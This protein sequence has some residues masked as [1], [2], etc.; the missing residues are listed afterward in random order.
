MASTTRTPLEEI[1][2]RQA[3]QQ[4][5][6]SV[7]QKDL[8]GQLQAVTPGSLQ[9]RAEMRGQTTPGTTP[10]AGALIGGTPDQTK[11]Q[12]TP[13]QL[14]NV[15]R[16]VSQGQ[17]VPDLATAQRTRQASTEVD[18][19]KEV[20][21]QQVAQLKA[22][23]DHAGAA[24]A[25]AISSEIDRLRPQQTALPGQTPSQPGGTAPI[26]F[27][28]NSL[29]Y[30]NGQALPAGVTAEQAQKA[31]NG[32]VTA[33]METVKK[34]T[35][36]YPTSADV[37]ALF[38]KDAQEKAAGLL[39]DATIRDKIPLDN[40]FVSNLQLDGVQNLDQLNHTYGL[41]LPANATLQ[42]F[43]QAVTKKVQETTQQ[44]D[45]LQKQLAD[46][47]TSATARAE[48]RQQLIDMG[49]I[50]LTAAAQ[51][52]HQVE[53]AMGELGKVTFGGK[54]YDAEE[55][56][57]DQNF[58]A[59]VADYYKMTPE[60]QA[61]FKQSD[62]NSKKLGEWLDT[63]KN[64][65]GKMVGEL[66]TDVI[67]A[68]KQVEDNRAA[69][70]TMG[71]TDEKFTQAMFP[72]ALK[73]GSGP[74]AQQS[75]LLGLAQG[76]D[77][78]A[79]QALADVQNIWNSANVDQTFLKNFINGADKNSLQQ[80]SG[81]NPA[82]VTL[83]G[84]LQKPR[85]SWS[86]A[87]QYAFGGVKS[88]AD[89][90][91]AQEKYEQG[92]AIAALGQD[93]NAGAKKINSAALSLSSKYSAQLKDGVLD[94]GDIQYIGSTKSGLD[95]LLSI[96]NNGLAPKKGPVADQLTQ[97][98][99][100]GQRIETE[101]VATPTTVQGILSNQDYTAAQPIIKDLQ[102]L[103]DSGKISPEGTTLLAQLSAIT[104][105]APKATTKS[106]STKKTIK[107]GKGGSRVIQVK[108]NPEKEPEPEVASKTS[109]TPSPTKKI[110]NQ[111]K[112]S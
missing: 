17:P 92:M 89:L 86:A 98:I 97:L 40:T 1:L 28:P 3:A 65:L 38:P 18:P 54:Q 4:K 51:D 45:D 81:S 107:T 77:K 72:D 91:K 87:E 47:N 34:E 2:Q 5:Q 78:K 74:I 31:V 7:L 82:W 71:L 106:S 8:S 103:K 21:L 20:R 109:P 46:P 90:P 59:F 13:A 16:Q 14:L 43:Q 60:D 95:D 102:K 44:V 79:I 49:A 96:Q 100:N 10:M 53:Q 15:A 85:K 104:K 83:Q 9:Q 73:A 88:P 61:K 30:L 75:G 76:G 50:G 69:L 26:A 108:R 56:F 99:E 111:G 29:A 80:L 101:K 52:A 12:G 33:W 19:E 94:E 84:L 63:Q 70:T 105:P 11:M 48:A 25:S 67:K 35:G 27:S 110:S 37:L 32:D 93:P 41:N 22:I 23:G 68:G 58:S 64:T 36:A 6:P 57:K 112:G 55:L 24:A 42:D 39:A 62:A 66:Q